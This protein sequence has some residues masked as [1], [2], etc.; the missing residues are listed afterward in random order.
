M[1]QLFES[2]HHITFCSHQIKDGVYVT[3]VFVLN[4]LLRLC[5][6]VSLNAQR[7]RDA[8]RLFISVNRIYFAFTL[9]LVHVWH[10]HQTN[11][12]RLVFCVYF[13]WFENWHCGHRTDELK[14]CTVDLVLEF[15]VLRLYGMCSHTHNI[16]HLTH[17]HTYTFGAARDDAD[18][19]SDSVDDD[20]DLIW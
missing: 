14:A 5:V 19:A 16:H 10:A 20:V 1:S 8:R 11:N 15:D 2:T 9:K 6:C 17:T 18:T 12:S 7:R 13:V 4:V 3:C